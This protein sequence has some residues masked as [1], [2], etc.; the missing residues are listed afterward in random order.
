MKYVETPWLKV[1]RFIFLLFGI[2]FSLVGIVDYLINSNIA[3]LINGILWIFLAFILTVKGKYND[4]KL[5]KLMSDG[6]CFECEIIEV[7]PIHWIRIGSYATVRLKCVYR[8]NEDEHH[9]LSGLLILPPLSK[10]DDLSANAYIS[11]EDS[12]K[13]AVAA[14]FR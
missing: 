10:L 11:R 3:F 13:Y 9:V 6:N 2:P 5:K 1:N 8:N 14:F 4:R 12:K 7:I